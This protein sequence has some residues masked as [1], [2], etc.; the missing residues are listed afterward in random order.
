MLKD[1]DPSEIM[2]T[3]QDKRGGKRGETRL[4][5]EAAGRSAPSAA[6]TTTA[7]RTADKSI[8]T[9]NRLKVDAHTETS[10]DDQV[11]IEDLED[12]KI[13]VTEDDIT[14]LQAAIHESNQCIE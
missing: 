5:E 6:Q 9:L 11:D 3:T 8:D 7:P 1:H 4:G 13:S 2:A 12:A 14:C 10:D